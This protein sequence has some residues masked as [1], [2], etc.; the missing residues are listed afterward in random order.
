MTAQHWQQI[1]EIFHQAIELEP[2][3]RASFLARVCAGDAAL[4][5][6]VESLIA[7]HEKEG[8]FIDAPAYEVAAELLADE[9]SDLQAGQAVGSYEIISLLS[10]GGMGE[11]YLAQER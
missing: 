8:S 1:K 2:G 4:R 11:V 5:K 6:E 10:V 3:A 9:E 7:A